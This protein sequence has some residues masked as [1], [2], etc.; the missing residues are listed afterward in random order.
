MF[1]FLTGH[2]PLCAAILPLFLSEIYSLSPDKI[3]KDFV[4]VKLFQACS[5]HWLQ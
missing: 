1:I 5:G 4:K 2:L 3:L